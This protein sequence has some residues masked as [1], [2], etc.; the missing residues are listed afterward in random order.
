ML[1]NLFTKTLKTNAPDDLV[2][3]DI[4]T[5]GLNH[6]QGAK[7]VEIAM[8]KI[9]N[10]KEERFETL[11]NP[12]RPIPFECSKIHSI[13]DNMVAGSPVFKSIAVDIAK[14]IGTSTVVCHNAQ[15]DLAFVHKELM[16]SGIRTVGIY[17]IDTLKL[18]RQYFSFE[19]NVLGNIA[20][21]IGVEVEL[22]H[23]AMADVLTMFSVS[24]YLFSNMYRKGID[25]IEPALYEY[26][27]RT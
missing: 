15:F 3:L 11:V 21:T 10:G 7:I 18:A 23:R 24:K 9:Q 8:L 20:N 16:E 22:K 25:T 13:Y 17:Y 1:D 27:S 4:E 14:F 12:L 5:T 19:S 6:L 2:Y 26:N